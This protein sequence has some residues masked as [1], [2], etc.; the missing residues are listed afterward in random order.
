MQRSLAISSSGLRHADTRQWAT[1]HNSSANLT[2]ATTV[3]RT[4]AVEQPVGGGVWKGVDAPM[5]RPVDAVDL[6]V[7]QIATV[8]CWR[9]RQCGPNQRR[10]V[11]FPDRHSRLT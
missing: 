5:G 11:G 2:A 4:T 6:A 10:N 8:S 9:C 3:V 1:A 7:E